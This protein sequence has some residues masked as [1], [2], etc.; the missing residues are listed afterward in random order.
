MFVARPLLSLASVT[1]I[2][3]SLLKPP[4]GRE[5]TPSSPVSAD[6]GNAGPEQHPWK[7]KTTIA[8]LRFI[9]LEYTTQLTRML[10]LGKFFLV[11]RASHPAGH[12]TCRALAAQA[13][14]LPKALPKANWLASKR[15][16]RGAQ[17]APLRLPKRGYGANQGR[18][19]A[20]ELRTGVLRADM[21]VRIEKRTDARGI[22]PLVA[23]RWADYL[24][25]WLRTCRIR[26]Q[27]TMIIA[28]LLTIVL[29]GSPRF[30][31][32]SRHHSTACSLRPRDRSATLRRTLP[33]PAT[34]D[35]PAETDTT[36]AATKPESGRDGGP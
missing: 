30:Q 19:V 2:L 23:M 14:A 33:V 12:R 27:A 22:G 35:R 5:S 18:S 8:R 24:R 6:V 7:H 26:A 25:L 28:R 1:V 21:G 10:R 9:I 31:N 13:N 20:R 29:I 16:S 4:S 32:R 11:A 15:R 3:N 34:P 36:N 17:S